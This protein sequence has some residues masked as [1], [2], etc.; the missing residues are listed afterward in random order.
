MNCAWCTLV[1]IKCNTNLSNSTKVKLVKI[2]NNLDIAHIIMSTSRTPMLQNTNWPMPYFNSLALN[3]WDEFGNT[4]C[5]CKNKLFLSIHVCRNFMYHVI[6]T[7][8]WKAITFLCEVR[9]ISCRARPMTWRW[10]HTFQ[11]KKPFH[12]WKIKKKK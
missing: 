4:N 5:S 3:M 8:G 9:I 10:N 12:K 7:W 1:G 11:V 2:L 6:I